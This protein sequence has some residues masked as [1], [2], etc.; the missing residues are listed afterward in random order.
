[1]LSSLSEEINRG[2]LI[3]LV[4]DVFDHAIGVSVSE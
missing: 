2:A 1:M 4:A 3:V